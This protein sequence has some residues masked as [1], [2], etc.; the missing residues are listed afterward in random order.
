MSLCR[1]GRSCPGREPE[2]GIVRKGVAESQRH[3]AKPRASQCAIHN[4]ERAPPWIA[5]R[6]QRRAPPSLRARR[7]ALRRGW[8]RAARPA[9]AT[10]YLLLFTP[11]GGGGRPPPPRPAPQPGGVTRPPPGGGA[12]GCAACA[13]YFSFLTPRP[14]EPRGPQPPRAKAR[15][16]WQSMQPFAGCR[17]KIERTRLLAGRWL[18]PENT[19]IFN[20]L[21]FGQ[22]S[23]QPAHFPFSTF[24]FQFAPP[25]LYARLFVSLAPPRIL[26]LGKTQASLLL[27]SLIRIFGCAQ[28][29]APRKKCK[30]A[31]FFH[32]AYSYL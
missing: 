25:C 24:H 5:D 27:P 19:A 7:A 29:T 31:C 17:P 9:A 4:Y 28:D 30:Q 3:A 14:I 32:S 21:P 15:N 10:L 26:P 1:P 16:S 2:K 11:A 20:S 8:L 13:R 6:S 12:P 22:Q 23:R 18:R